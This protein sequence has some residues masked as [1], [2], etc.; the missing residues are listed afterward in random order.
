MKIFFVALKKTLAG[1][2]VRVFLL[3][4]HTYLE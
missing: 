3:V 4:Q 1:L 2:S